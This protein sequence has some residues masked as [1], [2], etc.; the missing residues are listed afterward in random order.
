MK[1]EKFYFGEGDDEHCFQL[2]YFK[3]KVGFGVEEI[4]LYEAKRDIGGEGAWCVVEG[5]AIERGSSDCGQNC[6]QYKPR[7]GKNGMC[8]HQTW[9]FEKTGKK[10]RLHK[11]KGL[12]RL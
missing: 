8:K 7:N 3:D 2:D 6:G 4:I 11:M 5:E 10:F 1:R 9:C 12:E